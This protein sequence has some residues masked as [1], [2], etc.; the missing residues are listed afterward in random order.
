MSFVRRAL[1]LVALAALSLSQAGLATASLARNDMPAWACAP[2]EIAAAAAGS[3]AEARGPAGGAAV[4]G[5]ALV[6]DRNTSEVVRDLPKEAKGRAPSNFS[7]TVSVYW[8]VVTDGAA[9]A[10]TDTQIRNQVSAINRGFSGGEGGAATGFTFSLAGVTR[11]NN[12][13][14]YKSQSA[15]AEHEMKRALKQ[16]G[17]SALNVYSTSGG[18]LLGYAYLPEITD[19]AQAYLDGIVIDWRTMPGVS[20]AYAGV[21]DEGDTLTHE[22]GHWLNL[23]HTFF[24]QC[25]KNG[26]FV[27]DTPPQKSATS[28]CPTG[29]DT[30]PA[31]GLDPIHNYMDYSDDSCITQFTPGQVQRMRDAWLFYR[32]S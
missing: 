10:V 8:H 4:D 18:A 3:G 5:E 19:T 12:A 2:E 11:T 6:R 29:K 22:A 21:S 15:G 17:D 16:G 24:G 31:P 14:W 23:E 7:V 32:A 28:G 26:D 30:C 1:T 9:G 27:S 20:T 13:V 25:N